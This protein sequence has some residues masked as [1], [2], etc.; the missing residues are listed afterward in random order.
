MR[1]KEEAR[2]GSSGAG[3]SRSCG[4][5]DGLGNHKELDVVEGEGGGDGVCA[6]GTVFA[7]SEQEEEFDPVGVGDLLVSEG[8]TLVN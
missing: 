1:H 5:W 2:E 8:A 6:A 7:G 3:G 4:G